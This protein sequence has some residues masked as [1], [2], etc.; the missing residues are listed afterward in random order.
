MI[1]LAR[2]TL[3]YEWRRFLPAVMAVTFAGLLVLVQIGLLLGMFG[4]VSI[5]VDKSTAHVWMGYRNLQSV[6]FGR[7]IPM[8]HDTRLREHAEVLQVEHMQFSGGDWRTPS[9]SVLG[10]FVIGVDTH[11]EALGMAR[12][13]TPDQRALLDEPDSILVGEADLDKLGARVGQTA[14]IAGRRVRVV[15]VL[16]DLRA[17]GSVYVVASLSTARRLL[18]LQEREVD[19]ATFALARLADPTRAEAVRDAVQS[20]GSTVTRFGVW[21]AEELSIMSQAYWLLESGAGAGSAFASLL[22]I[23]VGAVITSQTLYAAIVA[24]IREYATLRALG[25]PARSLRAVVVEQSLWV[26]VAG[27]ALTC[28]AAASAALLADAFHVALKLPAWTLAGTAVLVLAI[29]LASGL[30]AL[31]SLGRAEPATLLR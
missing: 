28:V 9:G 26:G 7:D 6:D 8:L 12:M 25:V 18:S 14:E 11:R 3:L 31:R 15:G 13:I 4:T 16:R 24:S 2:S 1:S 17:I 19:M 10:A 29:S 21:T 23:V 30:F 22:G 20:P 27:L 5:M